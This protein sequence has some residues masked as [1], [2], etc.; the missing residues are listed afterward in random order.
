MPSFS[1]R[2]LKKLRSCKPALQELFAEVVEHFDCTVIDGH[3]D[4]D[5]QDDLHR[6]GLTQLQYPRSKHNQEPSDAV[7][8]VPYPIDWTNRD[9][10]HYFAGFV[11]AIALK[12]GTRIRWGGDWDTDTETQD[13]RF[14]DLPH[15][16][17]IED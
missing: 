5:E 17:L 3:R 4:Q 10:M 6:R 15:F 14:D 2:S 1:A 12:Q 7:D 9:R 16:E 8:V 11:I 13:N